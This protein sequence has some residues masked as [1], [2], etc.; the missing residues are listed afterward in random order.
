MIPYPSQGLLGQVAQ[1]VLTLSRSNGLSYDAGVKFWYCNANNNHNTTA[2][3]NQ[4]S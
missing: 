4:L 1:T 3:M 2:A